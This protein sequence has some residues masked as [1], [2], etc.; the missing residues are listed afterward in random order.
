LRAVAV[1]SV[2]AFHAFPGVVKGG[3]IGVDVFFIISGFLI[4]GIIFDRMEGD[5]FSYLEFYARRIKRIFPALLVVLCATMAIGRAIL[6]H[7]EFEQ[8]GKHAISGGWFASNFVLWSE[9]GYF[10][11]AAE[12]KPLLHLWSLA[13]EE[14][15][16]F[17]WPLALG[18][19]WRRKWSFLW[20]AGIVCL[21]SFVLNIS[22]VKADPSAAFY[23][24]LSRFWELILGGV[25]A[26]EVRRHRGYLT[27]H[28]GWVGAAG[29]ALIG[30]GVLALD[31][32]SPFPGWLALLPTVGAMAVIGAGPDA[33]INRKVLSHPALVWF[34][35]ISYP[36]YL[37]HWPI[38]SYIHI[39]DLSISMQ[40]ALKIAAILLSI[41]LS[42]L[43][44]NLVERRLRHSEQRRTPILLLA[45][46][47]LVACLGGLAATQR[48]MPRDRHAKFA[49]AREDWAYPEATFD[50]QRINVNVLAGL[51]DKTILFVGD[52]HMAQYYPAVSSRYRDSAQLPKYTS[53]F[54]AHNHCSPSPSTRITSKDKENPHFR[55]DDLFRAAMDLAASPQVKVVVFGGNWKVEPSGKYGL[56]SLAAF[57]TAIEDLVKQG[58]KVFVILDNAQGEEF[59]PRAILRKSLLERLIGRGSPEI[60]EQLSVDARPFRARSNARMGDLPTVAAAR[61]A[62]TVDP[63]SFLCEQDACPVIERGEAVYSDDN[64]VRPFFVVAR[65]PA[66][67][68]ALSFE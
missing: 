39:C 7:D 26:H 30:L 8:L 17:F 47:L 19:V 23:S 58:K 59:D 10:D 53:V 63:Y 9:V 25:L 49:G 62:K 48:L 37:W 42:Y 4:S 36:L 41:G 57:G 32:E 44:V 54:A 51:S 66:F 67:L 55:C 52:S 40:R 45:A 24:P 1:L 61:G 29:L 5:T 64:H 11:T 21:L 31:K 18:F 13:I 43:T 14:Q 20:S 27:Q 6:L 50:G 56:E 28:R 2:V 15:F 34:G 35:T 22:W 33:P 60:P 68:S 3:F 16:Y 65:A 12:S 46:M 38:L